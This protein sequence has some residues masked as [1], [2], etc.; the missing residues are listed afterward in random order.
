MRK[1]FNIN[2]ATIEATDFKVT[3]FSGLFTASFLAFCHTHAHSLSEIETEG[4]HCDSIG[5]RFGSAAGQGFK[6]TK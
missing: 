4:I 1:A 3:C 6:L 2:I 5:L